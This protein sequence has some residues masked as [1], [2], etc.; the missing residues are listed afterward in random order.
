MTP[1]V[2]PMKSPSSQRASDAAGEA[3]SLGVALVGA[4]GHTGAEL[5][6]LIE[7]HPRLA[8][9]LAASR[10]LKGQ[11]VQ[12]VDPALASELHFVD[13]SPQ[14]VARSGAAV[15][16]L[17]LPNDASEP[18]VKG[19]NDAC[20][21]VLVIDLSADHRF[22]EAWIYGLTELN[23]CAISTSR[24]VANP[25]CYATG[26]MLGLAPLRD[27]FSGP[28]TVF[29]VSGF[30]GAGSTPSPRNDPEALHANLMPYQLADHIHEREV[31]HQLGHT[32]RFV[33]HVAP[34][35]RGITLTVA[36]TLKESTKAR[37]MVEHYQSFYA[38]HALVKVS[39]EEIPFVRDA[40]G[41]HVITIGGFTISEEH[42]NRLTLVVTLDNLLKGAATQAVQNINLAS[43]LGPL[44]GI[45]S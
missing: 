22:D 31:S 36:V 23:A 37:D 18:Y 43:G 3:A 20:P 40:A 38:S 41:S 32:V 19:I 14:E 11:P 10:A 16:V 15:I 35:F 12:A 17:A 21:N 13:A 44:E 7:S 5:L 30:S 6:R 9:S 42:P 2:V 8:L 33:P 45:V 39:S 27:R 28:P 34:F 26:M 1:S 25:G 24:R 29:G 4:R